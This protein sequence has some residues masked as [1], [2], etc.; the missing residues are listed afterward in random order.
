MNYIENDNELIYMIND[1]NDEYRYILFNKYKPIIYSIANDYY[2]KFRYLNLD[3][4]D[5]IQEGMIGFNNAINTYKNKD[6]IFYTYSSICI[7]RNIISYIRSYTAKK[8]SILNNALDDSFYN[9]CI[10]KQ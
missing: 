6:S 9:N 4:D 7:K 8:N 5:L 10:V 3:F 2:I 1:N